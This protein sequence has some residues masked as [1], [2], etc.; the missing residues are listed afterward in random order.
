M[1]VM[2]V[3][4]PGDWNSSW[5]SHICVRGLSAFLHT[6]LE[7]LG[8]SW[9]A[10]FRTSA[11]IGCW[12]CRPGFFP[13]HHNTGFPAYLWVSVVACLLESE[14]PNRQP[15]MY[16]WVISSCLTCCVNRG[17]L[18]RASAMGDLSPWVSSFLSGRRWVPYPAHWALKQEFD[19]L[20][21]CQ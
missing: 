10:G 14:H 18:R 13:L 17:I 3:A 5:D 9:A 2:A 8:G 1:G 21:V 16:D 12:I 6:F 11:H 19:R 4:W 15:K 20:C 7:S